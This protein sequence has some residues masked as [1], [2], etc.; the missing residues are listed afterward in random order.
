MA[1]LAFNHA[2]ITFYVTAEAETVHGRVT[3][4]TGVASRISASLDSRGIVNFMMTV[5]AFHSRFRV[6]VMGH[7]H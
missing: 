4:S 7:N 2:V 6:G 3:F 5:D 1:L